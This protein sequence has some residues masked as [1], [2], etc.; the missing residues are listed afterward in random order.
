MNDDNLI[1]LRLTVN[2]TPVEQRVRA[3]RTLIDFLHEEL[4]LTGTKFSCGIGAC[5]ACKVAVQ[6]APDGELIPVLACFARLNAVHGMHVTTVE[7]LAP[8][9][10]LHPL[11]QAFLDDY[12]FQCGFSTP[13]FLMAGRV[14]LDRLARSPVARSQLDRTILDAIGLHVCRCT[15]Y[16]RYFEAIRRVILATPGLVVDDPPEVTGS[17]DA[18]AF[19]IVKQS[20]NDLQPK[21]LL[22]YFQDPEGEITFSGGFHFDTCR[23][24]V[25]V[26]TDKLST[27]EPVRD[28]N[29]AR[30]FF[31]G[32]QEIRFT[33]DRIE[34]LD[35]QI[36]LADLALG[37]TVPVTLHGVISFAGREMPASCDVFVCLSGPDR[38]RLISRLPIRFDMRD[39][40]FAAAGFGE[41]FGLRLENEIEV[42]V[43][44]ELGFTLR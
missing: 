23:G 36:Q 31:V 12:A 4:G 11:Q 14:L 38:V 32:A 27:G 35:R 34:P 37:A 18:I 9:G 17:R 10:T 44:L 2:G 25:T 15:G 28:L 16:I 19:R 6:A 39:L 22:G 1:D 42:T 29:L 21:A 43:D 33:L 30:F 24:S 13:G 8:A 5:G 7:G 41:E 20:S 26:R 40:A 3:D